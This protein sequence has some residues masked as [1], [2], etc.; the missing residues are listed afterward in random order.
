MGSSTDT[1]HRRAGRAGALVAVVVAA[2]LAAPA[3]WAAEPGDDHAGGAGTLAF[4]RPAVAAIDRPGDRDWYAVRLTE[5]DS[6]D[7]ITVRRTSGACAAGA[8]RVTVLNPEAHAIRWATVRPDTDVSRELPKGKPG[9]YFVEIDAQ[10]E[11][12][13][14]G[15]GYRLELEGVDTGGSGSSGSGGS[16]LCS[17]ARGQ[18]SDDLRTRSKFRKYL[19]SRDPKTVKRYRALLGKVEAALREDRKD[20]RRY[21]KNK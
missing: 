20:V 2:L 8:L 17:G 3:A 9:R 14:G 16:A 13:C 6:F 7:N 19:K 18:L 4:G 12:G 21:C 15:L 10:G 1:C 11:P 5:N